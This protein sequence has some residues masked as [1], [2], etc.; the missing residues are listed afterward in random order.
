MDDRVDSE[1]QTVEIVDELGAGAE[2]V[3][4]GVERV[5][6]IRDDRHKASAE[7]VGF[8]TQ[9]VEAVGG[10]QHGARIHQRAG[11]VEEDRT[12][13]LVPEIDLDHPVPADGEVLR[14]FVADIVA[15]G[16]GAGRGDRHCGA[17]G[18]E[19]YSRGGGGHQRPPG[20][21]ARFCH[22]MYPLRLIPRGLRV[23]AQIRKPDAKRNQPVRTQPSARACLDTP[24]CTY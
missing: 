20:P 17:G 5:R 9:V 11:A 16:N 22:D 14:A 7:P 6:S 13:I 2:P 24:A 8:R 23:A 4:Q 19:C 12:G 15:I 18:G 21:G 1:G 10:R 3:V